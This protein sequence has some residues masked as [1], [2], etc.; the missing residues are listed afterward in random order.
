M[1]PSDRRAL[2]KHMRTPLLTF[3][4]LML[5][6][7]INVLLG[8]LVPE[9]PHIWIAQ[10]AVAS[11]MLMTVLLFSMEILHEPA[12]NRLYMGVGFFW[13]GIMFAITLVD[14]LTR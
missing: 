13:V 5:L 1:S 2:W 3:V 12:I 11:F 9:T 10:A 14:Y 6:L 7:G 4:A 8:W